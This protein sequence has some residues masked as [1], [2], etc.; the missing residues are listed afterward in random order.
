MPK[1]DELYLPEVLMSRAIKVNDKVYEQ[2]DWLRG[3]RGTFSRVVEQILEERVY[4]SM[5]LSQVEGS[6]KYWE[7][8]MK[9]LKAP[10]KPVDR[11]Q[12]SL[13]GL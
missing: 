11:D 4:M 12:L 8:Q 9:Q 13:P 1:K 6:L 10:Q 7:H 3:K 5:L 2:L